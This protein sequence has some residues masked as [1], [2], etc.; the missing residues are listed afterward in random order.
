MTVAGE[1][2]EVGQEEAVQEV[3]AVAGSEVV[4]LVMVTMW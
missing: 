4:G 3:E 1:I 2:E